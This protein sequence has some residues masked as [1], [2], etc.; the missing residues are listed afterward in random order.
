MVA[1][2]YGFTFEC[3]SGA[4]QLLF[5]DVY[6]RDECNVTLVNNNF[7]PIELQR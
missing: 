2:L 4:I 6:E 3:N 5:I 7:K 1:H